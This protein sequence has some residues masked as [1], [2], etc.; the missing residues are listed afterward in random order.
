MHVNRRMLVHEGCWI[1]LCREATSSRVREMMM[2]MTTLMKA[3]SLHARSLPDDVVSVATWTTHCRNT[4]MNNIH[5]MWQWRDSVHTDL[6]WKGVLI[7]LCLTVHLITTKS[8]ILTFYN[9]IT[10]FFNILRTLSCSILSFLSQ[11]YASPASE[12]R[13]LI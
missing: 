13:R 2:T 6:I 3:P 4:V 11:I 5:E 7:A 9:D 1:L 8:F 10:H 12:C